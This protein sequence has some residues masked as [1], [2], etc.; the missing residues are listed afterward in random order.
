MRNDRLTRE[1]RT[2]SFVF[3]LFVFSETILA[4]CSTLI[5][6]YITGIPQII[7]K[8]NMEMATFFFWK[9]KFFSVGMQSD[10]YIW[11]RFFER[12]R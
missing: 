11:P 1:K 7:R 5:I 6:H 12:E 10:I 4:Q 9:K 2:I 3:I 8:F